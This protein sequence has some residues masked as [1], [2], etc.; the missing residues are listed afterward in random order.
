MAT[1]S[2]FKNV[3]IKSNSSARKFASALEKS[4]DKSSDIVVQSEAYDCIGKDDIQKIFALG[5]NES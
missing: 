2:F 1:K 5:K 4:K 3:N